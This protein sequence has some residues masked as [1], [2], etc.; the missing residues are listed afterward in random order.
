MLATLLTIAFLLAA[1]PACLFA[2]EVLAGCWPGWYRTG[3]RN[4]TVS[5]P[6]LAVLI[7]AHNETLGIRATLASVHEEFERLLCAA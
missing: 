1:L 7:P 3:Q 5:R 6:R 2:L 4:N